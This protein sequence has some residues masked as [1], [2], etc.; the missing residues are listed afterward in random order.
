MSIDLRPGAT[1]LESPKPVPMAPEVAS[2]WTAISSAL[3]QTQAVQNASIPPESWTGAAADAAS[4]E[5]QALGGKLSDLAG[6]FP[7][8]AIQL[9]K[10]SCAALTAASTSASL[11]SVNLASTSPVA[12]L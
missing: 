3:T 7:G 2:R 11:A 5:I 10:A 6:A 9:L 12:G 1:A 8:P 4:S